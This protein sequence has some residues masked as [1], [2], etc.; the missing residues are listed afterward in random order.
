M[1]DNASYYLAAYVTAA[2][3]YGGYVVSL[4]VRARRAARADLARLDAGEEAG[5]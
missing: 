3:L 4:V 2:V 5:R 1:P